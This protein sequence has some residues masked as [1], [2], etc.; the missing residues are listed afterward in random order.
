[1]F[2]Y[3]VCFYFGRRRVKTTNSLLLSDRYFFVKKHLNF[4]KNNEKVLNDINNIVL[5]INNSNDEDLKLVTN[6]KNQYSFSDKIIIIGRDNSNYSYGGWN[7]S[8]IHQINLNTPSLH[9]FLCEDDY[10]PCDENF[11]TK[12][13]EF[14]KP[15]VIYVCQLYINNHA[16]ISNGFISYELI[17]DYYKKTKKL[18][19]LNNS[20]DYGNVEVNQINFL[21]NFINLR[22]VDI[23]EKYYSKFL[24]FANNIIIYGNKNGEELIKPIL[25]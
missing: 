6:I 1:M 8:L 2:D 23:S 19:L 13:I 9:A 22:C 12:F 3:I 20:Y 15:D 10:V 24:N 14:F 18:F 5:V 7:E 25:E 11:H 4:I 17:K 16:A 21:K